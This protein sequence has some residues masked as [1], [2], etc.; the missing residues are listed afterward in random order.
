M[1][2]TALVTGASHNIGQGIAVVLAEHGYDVAIT[3]NSR[4]EGALDTQN[5]IEALGRKC[6]V[7]QAS[8]NQPQVPQ[9]IVDQAHEDL[10]GHL[11]LLVCNAGNGDFRGSI[12]TATPENVDEVYMVNFR[13]YILC[14]G[15]AA[16]HMVADKT[17]G[18]I[19]FIT[20]SRAEMAYPDDYLY[21][22]FKACVKRAAE[23]MALDLS[24]YNIR[25]NCVAPGATWQPKPGEEHRLHSPFVTE[26]I[27]MHRVGTPRDNG[28][29][30]AFLASEKA[31]YIT[32]ITVRVDGGLILP[33]MLERDEKIPWV[34][35]DWKKATYEEAMQ[36]V[37]DRK[38]D[39]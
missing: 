17:E 28:E 3:Y 4:R 35:E 30:V 25:V 10:G 26:S 11:D 19:I 36:M 7:Y 29:V 37:Q 14:A 5:R 27:P 33:G 1:N 2:K 39:E 16:R 22:G 34:N 12:L 21:G 13:N 20:S 24:A 32:G 38:K 9:Q 15:A 8:L 31:S 23:S 18:S 6:F